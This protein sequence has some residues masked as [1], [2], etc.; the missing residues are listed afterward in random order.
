MT[1]A[2][3]FVVTS[4]YVAREAFAFF[5]KK[6]LQPS[7]LMLAHAFNAIP[8]VEDHRDLAKLTVAK[9]KF[10]LHVPAYFL[11]Q[12]FVQNV[13]AFVLTMA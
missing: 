2:G 11:T 10:M 5:R 6:I 3:F 4:N 12:D 13:F 9:C 7:Y 8:V 1:L